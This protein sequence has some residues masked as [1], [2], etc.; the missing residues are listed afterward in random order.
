MNKFKITVETKSRS[1]V[2]V[3]VETHSTKE[4]LS[5]TLSDIYAGSTI[6]IKN[7]FFNVSNINYIQVEEVE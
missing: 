5:S 3:D 2:A 1:K 4:E 6:Q 7:I